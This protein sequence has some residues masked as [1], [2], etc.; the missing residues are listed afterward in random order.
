LNWKDRYAIAP[1]MVRVDPDTRNELS[2]SSAADAFQI[3]SVV[4]ERF[5]KQLGNISAPALQRF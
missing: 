5:T 3:R 1:W 2:K 4:Q